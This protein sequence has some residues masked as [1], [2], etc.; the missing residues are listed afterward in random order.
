MSNLIN[1]RNFL[2]LSMAG[3]ASV[4]LSGCMVGAKI[5]G[6]P[7]EVQEFTDWTNVKPAP[8]IDFWSTHPGTS[9]DT[10]QAIVDAFNASQND[11]KVNLVTAG[12]DYDEAAQKFQTALAS[13]QL[14]GVT[15][16]SDVWWFRYYLNQSITPLNSL[17]T[18][19]QFDN[20]DYQDEFMKDYVYS[21]K[22]WAV[23]YARSTPLFYYNKTHW[24][25]AGLPDRAPTTWDELAG[26]APQIKAANSSIKSVFEFPNV[27]D[28]IDW[29]IES[30]LWGEGAAISNGWDITFDQAPAVAAMTKFQNWIYKDKWAAVSPNLATADMGAQATSCTISSTGSMSGLL[31]STDGKFDV[32]AGFMPG[33]SKVQGKVTPTGGA[34]LG[35]PQGITPEEKLSAGMF[36][37]FLTNPENSAKFSDATGYIPV[38]KSADTTE[39]YQKMPLA[40]IAVNQ[41]AQAR[42]QDYGR[43]FIP[44]SSLIIGDAVGQIFTQ[45]GDPQS[46]LSSAAQK[47]KSNYENDVQSHLAKSDSSASASASPKAS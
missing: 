34:G 44:G 29:Q 7:G 26:W 18:H 21:G 39:L 12:K 1:R 41:M 42:P 17:M 37:K 31:K 14:P 15:M 46:T 30:L 35:I 38:R 25:N 27:N 8:K 33:G 32:G 24:K 28:Y 19:L 13:K 45:K 40:K 16:F 43:V 6:E 3:I 23:P 9:Q 36:L 5:G 2:G 22:Q 20:A 11:V 47:I 4:G 10:E